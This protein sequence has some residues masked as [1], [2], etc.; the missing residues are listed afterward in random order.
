MTYQRLTLDP[1][2]TAGLAYVAAREARAALGN[3]HPLTA[4]MAAKLVHAIVDGYLRTGGLEALRLEVRAGTD[5]VRVTITSVCTSSG[6][7]WELGGLSRL[8]LERLA[9][10][11]GS[12]AGAQAVCWFELT[13]QTAARRSPGAA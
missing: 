11:W 5:R 2:S 9:T 13:R 8:L 12:A 6:G 7:Q 4:V 1:A 3:E 10:A